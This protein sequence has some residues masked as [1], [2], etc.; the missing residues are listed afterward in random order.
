MGNRKQKQIGG[1]ESSAPEATPAPEASST[2]L[3]SWVPSLWLSFSSFFTSTKTSA[4]SNASNTTDASR[5]GKKH[6]KSV[7]KSKGKKHQKSAKR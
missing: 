3:F 5:G 6:K 4:V 2:S 1:L 7:K